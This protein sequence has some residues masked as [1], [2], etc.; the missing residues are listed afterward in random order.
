MI[1]GGGDKNGGHFRYL[2]GISRYFSAL[3]QRV[4]MTCIHVLEEAVASTLSRLAAQ[5]RAV[6]V[7]QQQ[8][9]MQSNTSQ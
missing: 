5:G 7:S 4:Q 6:L 1:T 2:V 9:R 8:D 3:R